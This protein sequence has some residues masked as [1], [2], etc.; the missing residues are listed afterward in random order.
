MAEPIDLD[1]SPWSWV[2]Y[3]LVFLGVVVLL[4]SV[5][6]ADFTGNAAKNSSADAANSSAQTL[7]VTKRQTVINNR[8]HNENVAQQKEL[9][10]KDNEILFLLTI[11]A[12]GEKT[13]N[14]AL[15]EHSATLTQIA[16]LQQQ[17]ASVEPIIA[18]LP[19]ADS[20]LAVPSPDPSSW[21]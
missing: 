11:I 6:F 19:S 10:K 20:Y 5:I 2:R 14:D 9:D 8:H 18:G 21:T 4:G 3:V 12:N 17:L 7:H 16:A 15:M 1:P 13:I